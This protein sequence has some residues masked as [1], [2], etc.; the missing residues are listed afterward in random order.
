[1]MA[2]TTLA[3]QFG[4]LHFSLTIGDGHDEA[5]SKELGT[6]TDT[7][8]KISKNRYDFLRISLP[9]IDYLLIEDC[10]PV[11]VHC[12]PDPHL[13]SQRCR[14]VVKCPVTEG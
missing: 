14:I 7:F 9:L 4:L 1:M 3:L 10:G 8:K 12:K 11:T 13:S 5:V 2:R 6:G